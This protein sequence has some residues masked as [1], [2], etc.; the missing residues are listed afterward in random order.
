MKIKRWTR[1][2]TDVIPY[3]NK[4]GE[5]MENLRNID[6][7]TLLQ[8]KLKENMNKAIRIAK[9]NGTY[10]TKGEYVLSKDDEWREDN[11]WNRTWDD[12]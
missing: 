12:N 10:N 1:Q 5:L 4:E 9:N 7:I 2:I 8:T 3:I 6:K 11:E